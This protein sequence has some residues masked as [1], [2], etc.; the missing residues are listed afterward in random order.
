[1]PERKYLVPTGVSS[2]QQ[3]SVRESQHVLVEQPKKGDL[4][5]AFIHRPVN[6]RRFFDYFFRSFVGEYVPKASNV[7]FNL[8]VHVFFFFCILSAVW[9]T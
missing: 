3:Q 7:G 4:L 9:G 6:M 2:G 8:S 5:V 1:M